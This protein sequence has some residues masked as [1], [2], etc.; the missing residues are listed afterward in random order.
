MSHFKEL[1]A[2]RVSHISWQKHT[3]LEKHCLQFV[4]EWFKAFQDPKKFIISG[5]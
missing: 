4:P 1:P 2:G 5:I 3:D